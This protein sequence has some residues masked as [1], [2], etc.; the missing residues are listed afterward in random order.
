MSLR[1]LAV[2][3]RSRHEL[4]LA[5]ARKGFSAREQELAFAGLERFGYLDDARFARQRAL[6]LL[7]KGGLGR[8]AVLERLRAH[9]LSEE[10]AR[11][12]VAESEAELKFDE[13]ASARAVLR[14]RRILNLA[15]ARE[16]A[17][18]ARTLLS[19]GFSATVV[20]ELVGELPLDSRPQD[21]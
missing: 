1:L 6:T 13:A 17:R 18:A 10:Q 11:Q 20:S 16:S 2:R 12:A 15:D 21:D 19:R 5:L 4:Q 9:G 7:E 14:K 8:R 3:A